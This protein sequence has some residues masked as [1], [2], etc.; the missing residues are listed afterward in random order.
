MGMTF[1]EVRAVLKSLETGAVKDLGEPD[2]STGYYIDL[3][4]ARCTATF[5]A[6]RRAD[7]RLEV[8]AVVAMTADGRPLQQDKAHSCFQSLG[9]LRQK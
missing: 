3:V 5:G 7:G 6:S 9:L 8:G 1:P 4:G 2:G